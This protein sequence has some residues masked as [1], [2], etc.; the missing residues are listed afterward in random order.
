MFSSF[1][2]D[3]QNLIE[4]LKLNEEKI[5]PLYKDYANTLSKLSA[6]AIKQKT[7]LFFRF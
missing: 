5:L 7:G 2:R 1:Y 4:E 3:L 6:L